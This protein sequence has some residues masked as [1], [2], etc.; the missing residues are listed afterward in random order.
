M[1]ELPSPSDA[2]RLRVFFP[3]AGY[4]QT[5]ILDKIGI[6]EL[7]STRLR[8]LA[9]LADKTQEPNCLNT[10]LRWFWV[11]VPQES[12]EASKYVPPWFL[13]LALACNILRSEANSLVPTVMLSPFEGFLIAS[14]HTSKLDVADPDLVLWPNPSSRLLSR[15]TVRRPSTA[16]LDLGTGTGIQA[17]WAA[18]HS[19]KVI[20]TD[21]NKRALA[22][23]AFN[24]RLNGI[25]GIEFLFGD[26]LEPVAGQKFDLIISNPPFFISPSKHYLFCDNSMDLDLLCRRLIRDSAAHLNEDGYCQM[27]CEWA[28]VEGQT[29]QERVTEWFANTGCDAWIIKGQTRDASEYAQDRIRETTSSSTHDSDLYRAHMDY[30]RERKVQAIHDGIIAMHRRT[31]QNWLLIEEVANAPQEPFGETVRTIFAA[32]DFLQSSSSDEHLLSVCPKLSPHVRLEQISQQEDGGWK[33]K[34]VT[35]KLVKG[36]PYSWRVQPLVV[37]FLG[38]CD[39]RKTLQELTSEFAAQVTAPPEQVRK[40]CLDLIRVL[41]TRGFVHW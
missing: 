6:S 28:Q 32:R 27:L 12:A 2:E 29:W 30:Y 22:F 37:E 36:F 38:G 4:T 21:L 11:G 18:A 24:A 41:I 8:N 39:G 9:R 19:Q 40:E 3:E 10:L 26:G 20:A 35:L 23:A 16:T 1:L 14:D 15:F 17:L 34:S 5:N 31:G 33:N 7:P 13:S 25:E